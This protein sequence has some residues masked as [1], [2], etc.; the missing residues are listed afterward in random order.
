[1]TMNGSMAIEAMSFECIP[2]VGEPEIQCPAWRECEEG[3]TPRGRRDSAMERR[4]ALWIR[5]G[6]RPNEGAARKDSYHTVRVGRRGGWG[7]AMAAC[8]VRGTMDEVV[9]LYFDVIDG[10][11][12]PGVSGFKQHLFDSI[13][14][15][16]TLTPRHDKS[17]TLDNWI[18]VI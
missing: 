3:P 4:S 8:F 12:R 7:R 2:R 13:L 10:T 17:K 5:S 15:S 18:L 6:T 1:M 16:T 11:E 9:K 14:K